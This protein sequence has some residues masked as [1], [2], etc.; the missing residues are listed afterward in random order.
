MRL[1]NSLR[2][3][4]VEIHLCKQTPTPRKILSRFLW[5]S[6]LAWVLIFG[7]FILGWY[8]VNFVKF[9]DNVRII[10]NPKS[11]SRIFDFSL[12]LEI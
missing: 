1:D 6:A 7:K 8:S 4:E 9:D 10:M 2:K 3:R 5:Q 12:F 11:V